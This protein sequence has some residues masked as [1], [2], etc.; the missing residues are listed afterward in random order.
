MKLIELTDAEKDKAAKNAG[1]DSWDD[2]LQSESNESEPIDSDVTDKR[3]AKQ[4]SD[5]F[6]DNVFV[7]N[8]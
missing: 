5:K 7:D 6:T 3:K 1:Y 2:M 4:Y 8:G